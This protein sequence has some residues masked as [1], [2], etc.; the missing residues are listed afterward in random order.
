MSTTS[1][2]VKSLPTVSTII[3]KLPPMR[4]HYML[5]IAASLGYMF[6]AFDTYMVSFALP[7]ITKE[8]HLTPVFNGVLASAG[9]WGGFIAALVWGPLND[10]FGRKFSFAGTVLGFSLVSGITAFAHNTTQFIAFRFIAGLFLGGMVPVVTSLVAEFIAAKHRGRFISVAPIFWPFGTFAAAIAAYFLIPRFGW[11]A[12]FLAGVIPAFLAFFV[13]KKLP[14][15]P[16][17]LGGKGRLK[18]AA[19]VLVRLGANPSEVAEIVPD[20]LAEAKVSVRTLLHPPYRKRFILTTSVLFF[21]YF[22]I[23]GFNLWLPSILAVEFKLSLA[24]TFAY[25]IMVGACAVLGKI[26]AFSTIDK[27]GRR[28]LFYVGFGLCG[29]AS[30]VFGL[31]REPLALALG[32][33]AISYTMEIGSAGCVVLPSE[34]FPSQV[35]G[36]AASWTAASGNLAS[37]VSPLVFGFFMA[38]HLYYGIFITMAVFFWVAVIMVLTMGVETKGKALHDVGA[39]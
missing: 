14:E 3:E 5:A 35:R 6:D 29:L 8:W 39:S 1:P 24:K 33:C 11:R 19:A 38:R 2:D 20:K 16:R 28:Q 15:S 21:G 32:A 4:T 17:W 18:E 26:T 13:I 7:S 23:R 34:L 10:K 25:T 31:L 37:A 30:L 9:M 36:T 22:G 12:L 27:F